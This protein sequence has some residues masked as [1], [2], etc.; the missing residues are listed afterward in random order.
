MNATSS[1]MEPSG[2]DGAVEVFSVGQKPW[3]NVGNL[4]KTMGNV[5]KTMGKP[6]DTLK[7]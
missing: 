1:C 4:G 7:K 6:W 5:G 2:G 3:K